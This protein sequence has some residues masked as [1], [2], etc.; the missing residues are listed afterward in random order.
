MIKSLRKLMIAFVGCFSL[1]LSSC[2]PVGYAATLNYNEVS[3]N[4][5]STK[6]L[7]VNSVTYKGEKLSDDKYSVTWS[8]SNSQIAKVKSTGVVTAVSEGTAT[9]T[10]NITMIL[11][12]GTASAKCIVNV[13]DT[14]PVSISLNKSS[15]KVSQGDSYQLEATVEHAQNKAV[16]WSS[17]QDFVTVDENGLV[18]VS[19][20]ATVGSTATITAKSVEDKTAKATC[21]ITVAQ[22]QEIT[23]SLNRSS[24]KVKVGQ[25]TT[26]SATVNNTADKT[27]T[28]SS[29]SSIINVSST[30][31]VSVPSSAAIGTEATITATSNADNT[32][33]ATCVVT[34]IDN[35]SA[36]YD[37]TLM[38][39]MCASTLEN[40]QG[41]YRP[42]G[43]GGSSSASPA[44]FTEDIK[45]MLSVNLPDSVKVIIETGGTTKWGMPSSYLDGATSI[46]A[47]HLQRWEIVDNKLKLVET[48]TTN[49]MAEEESFESFLEWGLENYDADQIGVTISGHGGGI[50]G[51]AY[52]DNDTY[53][54]ERYEYENS[55]NCSEIAEAVKEALNNT[56]HGKLTWMGFDCCLM[57]SAD[58]ASVLADYFDYMVGSTEEE[59]GEGWDHD[60]YMQE[61]VK[62]PT[63]SPDVLLPKICDS[64]VD[65][66]HNTYCSARE[67]CNSTLSVLDL[68]K[69][70]ELVTAF[71]DY[72]SSTGNSSTAY[73]KYK[74]AFTNAYNDQGEGCYGIVDFKSFM[75]KLKNQYS[76]ISVDDVLSAIDDVVMHSAVCSR[77]SGNPCGLNA[78]FPESTSRE[79][80]QPGK[81]DYT[82]SMATKFSSYQSMCLSYGDW[83][84]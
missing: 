25:T 66:V 48:L 74:T 44:L 80:L 49:L 2:T 58:I 61:L 9:I 60:T 27:V 56:G 64:F 13:I 43:G 78:F 63:V 82:G 7:V 46:S 84:W 12:I 52:D 53:T 6:T 31:V 29:N 81:E 57:Q 62:D 19:K 65:E 17:N 28:W 20:T 33:K 69:M 10:A 23:I 8:S 70:S 11:G 75:N 26:L 47:D 22:A 50:A 45:E 41:G 4:I 14:N 15:V 67:V 77:H 51:C 32:K 36:D 68:S 35:T 79:A 71:N 42:Y 21:K 54:Y 39:Y 5:D 76:S 40:E 37:Y 18:V 30:G 34:A 55:L 38:Y 72:V 73:S 83:T 3:M 1:M 16:E 24:A 59:A